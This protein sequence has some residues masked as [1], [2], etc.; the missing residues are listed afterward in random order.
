MATTKDNLQALDI[1]RN[2]KYEIRLGSKIKKIKAM[3]NAVSERCDEL[4]AR[5]EV[6]Y[7]E[8]QKSL[9]VNMG[10]NRKLVPKCVSLMILH[11]WFKVTFFHWI[12][13]RYLHIRYTM[14][15]LS[16]AVKECMGLSDVGPFFNAMAVLAQNSRIIKRMAQTNTFNIAQEFGQQQDT[17]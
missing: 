12:Y 1:D 17:K 8:D 16:Q 9:I 3:N 2:V 6:S 10:K 11:S 14:P 4:I 13:W 7:S 5:A 15:E